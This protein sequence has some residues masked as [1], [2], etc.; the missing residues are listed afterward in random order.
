[1]NDRINKLI[2]ILL[3]LVLVSSCGINSNIMFK[4]PKGDH[5]MKDSTLLMPPPEY[6]IAVDDKISFTLATNNGNNIILGISNIE[7]DQKGSSEKTTEYVV[8]RDGTA[9]LPILGHVPVVGLTVTELETKLEE[10]Y[11]AE[12]QKPFVQVNVTNRRVIVFPGNGGDAKVIT[13]NNN[14]TTLMEVIALA[15]GIAERGK[16]KVV[17]LMRQVNGE[18]KM[19]TFDLSSV[20]GLKYADIIVQSNDYI[21]IEPNPKIVRETLKEVAPVVTIISSTI[22]IVSFLVN[23]K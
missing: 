9:E 8:K 2:F 21:Y 16:A 18:R 22:I 20:D 17:K 12:Y 15:G 5:A 7:N 11:A 14:N 13:L 19:Y 6:R 1:M 10:L 23:L 4:A 3:L